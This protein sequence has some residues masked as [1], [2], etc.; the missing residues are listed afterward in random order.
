MVSKIKEL[1]NTYKFESFKTG[2]S[3]AK[4]TIVILT[5]PSFATWLENSKFVPNVIQAIFPTRP[6]VAE[7]ETILA[8]VD[9]LSP[10]NLTDLDTEKLKPAEGFSVSVVLGNSQTGLDERLYTPDAAAAAAASNPTESASITIRI[11]DAVASENK[12]RTQRAIDVTVPLAN[13]LFHNG[14]ASTLLAARW[15]RPDPTLPFARTAATA[16]HAWS[17]PKACIGK[18]HDAATRVPLTPVTAPRRI[19]AGLGNIVRQVAGADGAP[20]PASAE[21]E[22]AVVAYLAARALPLQTVAVWALVFPHDLYARNFGNWATDYPGRIWNALR[23]GATLHRV[24]KSPPLFPPNPRAHPQA[25]ENPTVSGGGGWGI[26]AGLL[27]LDPATTLSTAT[28]ARHDFSAAPAP[29]SDPAAAQAHALGAVAAP[30]SHIQFLIAHEPLGAPSHHRAQ[31]QSQ[32]QPHAPSILLGCVPSTVDDLP[33]PP[34][35]DDG[36]AVPRAEM[37]V[38]HG[39]ISALSEAGLYLRVRDK[40]VKPATVA[41]TRVDVPGAVIWAEAEARS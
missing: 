29:L 13:T 22:E 40:A 38:A 2:P 7:V 17:A 11:H 3:N 18:L 36:G 20:A 24:R 23:H 15:H 10:P 37:H 26:K 32:L 14:R 4:K 19:A 28:D 21:L 25:N 5:T 41:F 35:E 16:L 39:R 1:Q 31:Q 9:G 34:P 6:D 30:G 33:A 8:V 27:A 12:R